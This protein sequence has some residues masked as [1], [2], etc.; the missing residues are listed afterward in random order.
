MGYLILDLGVH[1]QESG[2]GG[3]R[4]HEYGDQA[5]ETPAEV[6][7]K[8]LPNSSLHPGRLDGRTLRLDPHVSASLRQWRCLCPCQERAGDQST[9]AAL[10]L[11]VRRYFLEDVL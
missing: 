11:G 7:Q 4:N 8:V 5:S 3:C 10:D 9:V 6:L 1:A 2:S